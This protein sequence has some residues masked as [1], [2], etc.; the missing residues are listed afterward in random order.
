MHI[1]PPITGA[2]DF[3]LRICPSV[4]DFLQPSHVEAGPF[5]LSA[6]MRVAYLALARTS[7][8]AQ[9][10]LRIT[11]KLADVFGTEFTRNM[12]ENLPIRS[13]GQK[14]MEILPLLFA[15]RALL[16]C[17][18]RRTVVE[19]PRWIEVAYGSKT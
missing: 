5:Y 16:L 11:K 17:R 6:P 2:K 1:S 10:L 19:H 4:G 9:W 14:E 18:S 13:K 8:E 7:P 3:A 12:L 15:E